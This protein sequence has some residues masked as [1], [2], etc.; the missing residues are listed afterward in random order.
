MHL[1]SFKSL[2]S[3]FAHVIYDDHHDF[4]A[5]G[6]FIKNFERKQK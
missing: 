2:Q 6:I 3:D 1:F 5:S 4:N